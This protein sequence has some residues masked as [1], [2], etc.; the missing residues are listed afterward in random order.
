MSQPRSET[1]QAIELSRGVAACMVMLVH[2]QLY[3][4]ELPSWFRLLFV[5]VDWFFVISG[6][7]FA[8]L[9]LGIQ[10]IRPAAFALRR[11]GRLLPLYWTSLILYLLLDHQQQGLGRDFALH[12]V[13][14]QTW[15]DRET[16][17]RFNP[18]YWSLPAE[19]QFY[20]LLPF[21]AAWRSKSPVARAVCLLIVGVLIRLGISFYHHGPALPVNWATRLWFNLPGQFCEFAV[22]ILLYAL[23]HQYPHWRNAPL[24]MVSAVAGI[25]LVAAL[26][27]WFSGVGDVLLSDRALALTFFTLGVAAG[28]GML[29]YG[30]LYFLDERP[31]TSKISTACF[32]MGSISYAV[33][34]LHNAVPRIAGNW[35]GMGSVPYIWLA[36]VMATLVLAV[37]SY[38]YIENPLRRMSRRLA[39]RLR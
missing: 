18:A 10:Q 19:I 36:Y 38:R 17:F 14:A 35:F 28:F 27:A 30:L 12:A 29:L 11:A 32:F 16:V 4:A 26:L 3:A 37:L 13:F 9:A 2:Y 25:A 15:I 39:T 1:L 6:F 33:Y 34:L 22:G 20:A 8:P 7:L 24:A 5:G 23:R 31:G 21:L